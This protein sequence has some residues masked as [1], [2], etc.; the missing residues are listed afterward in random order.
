MGGGRE[1]VD[2]LEGMCAGIAYVW[3]EREREEMRARNGT[4]E[5][6]QAFGSGDGKRGGGRG[7]PVRSQPR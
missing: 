3:R 4:C 6:R 7:A 5:A 2:S 1:P